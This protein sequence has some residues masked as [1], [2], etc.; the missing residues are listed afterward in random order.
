MSY[1]HQSKWKNLS[2]PIKRFHKCTVPWRVRRYNIITCRLWI[3]EN[4][5]HVLLSPSQHNGLVPNSMLLKNSKFGVFGSPM[6]RSIAVVGRQ[7][8]VNQRGI[9]A[10]LKIDWIKLRGLKGRRGFHYPALPRLYNSN[11]RT[12]KWK[13]VCRA[14]V[15]RQLRRSLPQQHYVRTC[16]ALESLYYYSLDVRATIKNADAVDQ[17]QLDLR[18]DNV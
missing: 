14:L 7:R 5:F 15:K 17:T 10:G 11:E 16:I 3:L 6:A 8:F 1:T 2:R 13:R 9:R 18:W 12:S 4:Y